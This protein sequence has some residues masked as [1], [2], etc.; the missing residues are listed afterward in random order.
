MFKNALTPIDSHKNRFQNTVQKKC[1]PVFFFSSS[2]LQI[3]LVRND[4]EHFE[5]RWLS[6]AFLFRKN[7]PGSIVKDS[8]KV[9]ILKTRLSKFVINSKIDHFDFEELGFKL[10]LYA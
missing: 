7:L 9:L 5:A 3:C 10:V 4:S 6:Y 8:L 2:I 1:V